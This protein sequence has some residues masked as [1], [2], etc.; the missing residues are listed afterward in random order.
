MAIDKEKILAGRE[1]VGALK[2]AAPTTSGEQV[3]VVGIAI[4]AD[5]ILFNP[6]YELVEV[7]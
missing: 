4:T 3:Q 5:I 1:A 2:N 6:S 7:A